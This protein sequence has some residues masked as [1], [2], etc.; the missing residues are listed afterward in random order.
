MSQNSTSNGLPIFLEELH[1]DGTN[2]VQFK[3]RV[4]IAAHA[5]GAK[6]YLNGSIPKPTTTTPMPKSTTQKD[7]EEVKLALDIN[8]IQPKQVQS[9]L[10]NGIC[11]LNSF[12]L[13]TVGRP[14]RQVLTYG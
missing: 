9:N 1:F 7:E 6:G 3:S 5:Q 14:N 2:F 8:T 10:L 12:I 11:N 13:H 4:L